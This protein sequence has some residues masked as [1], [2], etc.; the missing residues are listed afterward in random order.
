MQP[1][2]TKFYN[3]CAKILG[4][5]LSK[6]AT[7]KSEVYKTK[8]PQRFLGILSQIVKNLDLYKE[9]LTKT[10]MKAK[11]ES[12]SLIYIHE[13][14]NNKL[15]IKNTLT[16]QI[17]KIASEMNFADK[18]VVTYVRINTLALKTNQE[19][20][21]NENA[22]FEKIDYENCTG[23][24]SLAYFTT[25]IEG[26]NTPI[27]F[28]Y[29]LT[30]NYNYSQLECFTSG[31][32]IVQN[33]SSCLP[34]FVLNPALNSKV[35]DACA[36]PGNKTSHLSA[37]MKNTGQ[38]LAYEKDK[39]RYDILRAYLKKQN[40]VN[41]KA[42]HLDFLET[43]TE[44]E[45]DYIL[46]DPS[47]SASGVHDVY[48]KE[49]ARIER[50]ATFQK[51]ILCHALRYKNVKKVVYSTCSFHKEENEDVVAYCLERN[52]DFEVQK[53]EI[54]GLNQGIK[55]TTY[56]FEDKIL[57]IERNKEDNIQGFFVALF[58]RK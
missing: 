2:N 19:Q 10:N 3:E 34:A 48:D 47:C 11:S 16:E 40:C 20:F 28:V 55:D 22:T 54:C 56:G 38:L 27:P 24:E 7:L 17:K 8:Q 32:V 26:E 53:I 13:I 46:V 52:S 58:V 45:V 23:F 1:P 12:L 57:R 4:Q 35:I 21:G 18:S 6:K 41:V 30:K 31:L 37:L 50:L 15:K 29:K 33:F 25:E 49:D 5:I 43:D 39:R 36:A 44:T 14:V 9:I 42:Q 51:K